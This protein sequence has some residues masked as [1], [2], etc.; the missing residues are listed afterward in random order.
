MKSTIDL[1]EFDLACENFKNK[2]NFPESKRLFRKMEYR[3]GT[4]Q[5]LDQNEIMFFHDN[6]LTDIIEQL[7]KILT[8]MST[9]AP[10]DWDSR[11]E[12]YSDTF[13]RFK[14]S[15]NQEECKY[16]KINSPLPQALAQLITQTDSLIRLF[17][18]ISQNTVKRTPINPTSLCIE[19]MPDDDMGLKLLFGED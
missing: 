16:K 13:T 3:G 18:T 4:N 5:V 2:F 14:N 9:G 6:T 1:S 19:D 10:I 12:K 11:I 17:N 15:L 8:K 7:D